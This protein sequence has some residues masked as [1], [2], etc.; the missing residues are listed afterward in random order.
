MCM[1]CDGYAE[2]DW[3]RHVELSIAVYGWA[4]GGVEP[5]PQVP[6]EEWGV[7][8]LGPDSPIRWAFTIGMTE[9]FG[10]PELVMTDTESTSAMRMLNRIGNRLISGESLPRVARDLGVRTGQVRERYLGTELFAQWYEYYGRSPSATT[11]IQVHHPDA[12]APRCT[13]TRSR[14]DVD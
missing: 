7:P 9:E 1:F 12:C 8:E 10:L 4:I 6:P 14:L 2:A 5:G 3:R 11:F 13:P